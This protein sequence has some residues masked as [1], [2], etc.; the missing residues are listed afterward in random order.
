MKT[1]SRRSRLYIIPLLFIAVFGDHGATSAQA[2]PAYRVA[3]DQARAA[4]KR[5]DGHDCLTAA[6]TVVSL[7]PDYPPGIL[8]LAQAYALQKQPDRAMETLANLQRRGLVYDLTRD[9]TLS[10]ILTEKDLL[11]LRQ[12]FE[13]N[14]QPRGRHETAITLPAQSGIIESLAYNAANDEW[15]FSDVFGRRILKRSHSGECSEFSQPSD[16]LLGVFG[17]AIDPVHERLWASCSALPLIKAYDAA[18]RGRAELVGYDLKTGHLLTRASVPTDGDDHLLGDLALSATGEIFLT[19]TATPMIWRYREGAD[20]LEK[21]CTHPDFRSLQGIVS[22]APDTLLV[23]DYALGLFVIHLENK[24]VT[25]LHKLPKATFAGI[26]GMALAPRGLLLVQNGIDPQRIAWVHLN[27]DGQPETFEVLNQSV[28][29]IVEPTHIKVVG[30]SY[31]I[32]GNSGWDR[33]SDNATT[34]APPRDVHIFRSK[35]P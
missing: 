16:E 19:D 34:S 14:A 1:T 22:P 30:D 3:L 10:A 24:T 29:E 7:C 28:T 35:L 5:G 4:K 8:L 32:I 15:Y 9:A 17:L 33:F 2:Q 21:V 18:E 31:Y 11:Q 26:D 27:D 25:P 20:H 13:A 6:Q 12:G 23:A